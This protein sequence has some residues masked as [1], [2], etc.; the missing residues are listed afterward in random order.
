MAN[1][2]ITEKCNLKCS[3]CFADEF[4]NKS[5]NDMTKENFHRAIDFIMTDPNERIG[6]IGGEP[7]LHPHFKD[8]L[9]VLIKDNRVK[10]VIVFTNGINIH[11]FINQLTHPKF[12]LLINCNAPSEIGE[13]LFQKTV[14]NLDLLI[15]EFYMKP[16]ITIGINMHKP[17]FDFD[18]MIELLL[19]YDFDHV[20][21]SIIVPRLSGSNKKI[22]PIE[23]FSIMKP[24]VK[25]FFMKLCQYKIMPNYDCNIMP[26]CLLDENEREFIHENLGTTNK[27]TNISGE[28]VKCSPVIDILPDLKAVRCF[29]LSEYDKAN[30]WDFAD[31]HELRHYFLNRF[32]HFAYNTVA[33]PDC[34][35]CRKRITMK[36]SGGCYLFKIDQINQLRELSDEMIKMNA[37]G[38]KNE[39]YK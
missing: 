23:Y 34:I 39:Y 25:K 36:C 4:V 28:F 38:G 6:L 1:I 22:D 9:E 2:M 27:N 37:K 31:I 3:Y 17:D 29:G 16:K 18:Y 14:S 11:K 33:S 5:C 30:I 32:D 13:S 8:L 12:G 10:K 24:S 35:K 19:R 20:R 15:K 26:S 21:T 7:T